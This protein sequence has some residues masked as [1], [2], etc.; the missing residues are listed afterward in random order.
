MKN[1][2][3]LSII[4]S[5]VYC[6]LIILVFIYKLYALYCLFFSIAHFSLFIV[7]Y[8]EARK[9]KHD[10]PQRK[11]YVALLVDSIHCL[12]LSMIFM[13]FSILIYYNLFPKLTTYIVVACSFILMFIFSQ[14]N[15][16][17]SNSANNKGSKDKNDN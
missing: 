17:I 14:I 7:K 9:H 5:S 10:I 15:N 2:K 4:L 13:G 3:I 16:Y 12:I 11:L 8:I 1:K 6:I